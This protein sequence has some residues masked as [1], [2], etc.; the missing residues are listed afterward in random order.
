MKAKVSTWGNSLGI[1]IPK[2]I[3]EL[4]GLVNGAE[5]KF[6]VEG[7][8][9]IIT[10]IR[11]LLKEAEELIKD[12]DIDELCSQI[13]PENMHALEEFDDGNPVGKEIW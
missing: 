11:D 8:R 1:R 4:L 13:T 5:V 7:N 12:I 9:I 3:S 6:E 2:P 10:T